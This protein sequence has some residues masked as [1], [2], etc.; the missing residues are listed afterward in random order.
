MLRWYNVKNTKYC[1]ICKDSTYFW[2]VLCVSRSV[3][4]DSLQPHGL[5]PARLL[6]PWDSPGK[7]TGVGHH[8]LLQ[9]IFPT[10]G[11]NP[12]LLHCRHIL[13][14][15]LKRSMETTLSFTQTMKTLNPLAVGEMWEASF[16]LPLSITQCPKNITDSFS[17]AEAEE[18]IC[19]GKLGINA[20]R[21]LNS[22][23]LET[24]KWTCNF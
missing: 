7:N 22:F 14:Q 3:M 2:R 24:S 13:Y 18:I 8:A 12:R 20:S 10:Q 21:R 1:H 16:R 17:Q 11:L 9:G 5:H 19:S 6:W 4:S 15:H 23:Y